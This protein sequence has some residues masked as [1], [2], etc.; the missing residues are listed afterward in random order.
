[1]RCPI[2]FPDLLEE[3]MNNC[4]A[5]EHWTTVEE[6]RETLSLDKSYALAVS[7]FLRRLYNSPSV[8]GRYTV[9]RIENVRVD[10][11][12]RHISRRYLVRERAERR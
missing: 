1:M 4:N 7:G 10:H 8:P 11:P 9:V 6:F 3:F 2:C 12:N 5:T